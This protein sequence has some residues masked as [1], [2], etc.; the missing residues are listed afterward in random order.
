MSGELEE[1]D[2]TEKDAVPSVNNNTDDDPTSSKRQSFVNTLDHHSDRYNISV[3]E[4]L[5]ILIIINNVKFE[6]VNRNLPT[7]KRLSERIGSDEDVKYIKKTFTDLGWKIEEDFVLQ[8]PSK[9]KIKEQIKVIQETKVPLSCIAVFIMSHG[10]EYDTIWADDDCYNLKED[11]IEQLAAEN[12]PSLAGKPKMVFVQACQGGHADSG[13]WVKNKIKDYSDATATP[14]NMATNPQKYE[15]VKIPNYADIFVFKAA[16]TGYRCFRN[17]KGSWF[18]SA[19]CSFISSSTQDMDL[20]SIALKVTESVSKKE[21]FS[22]EIENDEKK[23]APM[24]QSTLLRKIFLK[25]PP[26]T[27]Q[28]KEQV[29]GIIARKKSSRW[30]RLKI[31]FIGEQK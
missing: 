30:K 2:L 6:K 26:E 14:S 1:N 5:K 15:Y 7:K 21:S 19:L 10:E 29:D 25:E 12:C 8:D 22:D 20:G 27:S 11:I 3:S 13:T 9:C 24:V 4:G 16:Y 18:M 17:P 31:Y 28:K 23:Q